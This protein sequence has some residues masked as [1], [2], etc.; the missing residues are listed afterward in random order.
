MS[1]IRISYAAALLA[2]AIGSGAWAA[3]LHTPPIRPGVGEK[4][5]CTVVNLSG[6][7]LDIR[8]EILDRWRDNVTCFVRTDWDMSETV[9]L[10]VHAEAVNPDARYCRVIVRDGRKSDVAASLQ[11]CTYDDTTCGSP[12]VA[13]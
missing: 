12:V 11:A 8:A 5:V 3:T 10:T 2:M 9:L 13:H 7:P 1:P 4:L 6:K